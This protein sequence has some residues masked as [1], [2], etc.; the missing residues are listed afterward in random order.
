[1]RQVHS[2]HPSLGQHA[3]GGGTSE[4]ECSLSKAE[5]HLRSAPHQ[6]PSVR[7]SPGRLPPHQHGVTEMAPL[8]PELFRNFHIPAEEGEVQ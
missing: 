6:E 4:R 1:M 8:R 5:E 7:Q 3:E 2:K